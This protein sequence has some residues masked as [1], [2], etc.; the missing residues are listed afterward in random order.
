MQQ[1][2]TDNAIA[3][4]FVY[5]LSFFCMGLAII[6]ELTHSSETEFAR[7][8]PPLAAFALIHGCHEWLEMFILIDS[9]ARKQAPGEWMYLVQIALLA[10]S[11][12]A[13]LGFGFQIVTST[14]NQR[15]LWLL[16]SGATV[17]WGVGILGI[18][19]TTPDALMSYRS[20]N[21]F[22]RYT[23]AIP[24]SLLTAWGFYKQGL[25][26][27]KT[28]LQRFS[29]DAFVAGA[30][31]LIYGAVGQ[32]FVPYSR[33]YPSMYINT[34][35][36]SDLF[37]FPIQIVRAS[38]AMLSSIF[39]VR[40][41]H[42]IQEEKEAQLR[43]FVAAQQAQQRR[44][45]DLRSELLHRTVSAQ[46][47]ERQRIAREL[48]DETGQTLTAL[49]MGLR[50]LKENINQNP[51][52]AA[53]QTEQLEKLATGAVG[54]LQRMVAGLHPSQLDDLG[55][56][57]ALRWFAAISMEHSGVTFLV[58]PA[59]Q[60]NDL[61]IELRTALF[62][63]AQESITNI[64]RHS[65]ASRAVIELKRENNLLM[66]KIRDN[67]CGFDLD[68]A[69][70]PA[71]ARPSWGLLGMQERAALIGGHLTIKSAL[72]EGAQISITVSLTKE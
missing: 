40:F 26:F 44:L 54:E 52:R 60:F 72:G 33:I 62:R 10:S 2:F 66:M 43:D 7:S 41:L 48:H 1:F 57:A 51:R 25:Q 46:E 56:V 21:A 20:A 39:V 9:A 68:S 15:N 30:A 5:G 19:L 64:I 27:W 47:A 42:A 55:L 28:P 31:F 58:Q 12:L 34:E 45:D 6:L 50:G 23:L 11:F 35:T 65:K 22:T 38:I 17:V 53:Q 24:A 8:L 36:F 69:L 32:L 59:G 61:S 13:M 4:Y 14:H 18:L 70:N 67:G 29:Y 16:M 71:S 63:I 49:S 3:V 37:H